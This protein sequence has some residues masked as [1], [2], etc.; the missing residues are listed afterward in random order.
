MKKPEFPKEFDNKFAKELLAYFGHVDFSDWNEKWCW[1][2]IIPKFVQYKDKFLEYLFSFNET[3][4]ITNPLYKLYMKNVINSSI[5]KK[6]IEKNNHNYYVH[7]I[8]KRDKTNNT[9]EW[10]EKIIEKN[11]NCYY[12]YLM[13]YHGISDKSWAEKIIEKNNNCYYAYLMT[14][15]YNSDKSWAEKII[16]KN[17]D[18]HYAYLMVLDCNSDK[19]WAEKI[20]EKNNDSE[21]AYRMVKNFGSSQEW[22]ESIKRKKLNEK[23]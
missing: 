14:L 19:S 5:I 21:Y 16:E 10:A 1:D 7:L 2:D 11:N 15:D 12:A 20:I 17:N 8:A 6:E 18:S 9:R 4:D 22:Y 3:H 13:I 23:T